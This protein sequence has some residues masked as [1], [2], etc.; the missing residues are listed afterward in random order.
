M[1][2]TSAGAGLPSQ[3]PGPEL[4]PRQPSRRVAVLLEVSS[5][6]GATTS[7]VRLAIMARDLSLRAC[8]DD[9]SADQRSPYV[10]V[11]YSYTGGST[12]TARMVRGDA[13][14]YT[15]VLGVLSRVRVPGATSWQVRL[16][17]H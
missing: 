1:R 17:L 15:C 9:G 4:V 12:F 14:V 7:D 8:V 11:A 6:E 2:W 13:A 3:P 5:A 10:I 16:G